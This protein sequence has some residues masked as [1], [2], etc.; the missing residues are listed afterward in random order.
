MKPLH[1]ELYDGRQGP[2]AAYSWIESIINIMLAQN[3]Q[4]WEEQKIKDVQKTME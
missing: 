1:D 3:D 4:I 2:V